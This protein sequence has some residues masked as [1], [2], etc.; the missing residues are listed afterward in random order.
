M[1]EKKIIL[2]GEQLDRILMVTALGSIGMLP[3]SELDGFKKDFPEEIKA[4]VLSSAVTA[5]LMRREGPETTLLRL[6]KKVI[7]K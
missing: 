5:N 1:N 6:L 3:P 7:K 2:T 4:K